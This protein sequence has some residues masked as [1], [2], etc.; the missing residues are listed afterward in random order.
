[1]FSLTFMYCFMFFYV[2]IQSKKIIHASTS[3]HDT[4]HDHQGWTATIETGDPR[5]TTL[6]QNF[7]MKSV[8]VTTEDGNL[9]STRT[10]R[11]AQ[12]RPDKRMNRVSLRL[13]CYPFVYIIC[14]LPLEISRLS[15]FAG[16]NWSLTFVYVGV[17]LF[18]SSGFLNALLYTTTRKGI[19]SWPRF[20]DSPRRNTAPVY[21][22]RERRPKFASEVVHTPPTATSTFVE[23]LPEGH[24]K[25]EYDSVWSR[26]EPGQDDITPD[27]SPVVGGH[28]GF[29]LV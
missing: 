4:L 12:L 25:E 15:Q 6:T 19:I 11:P 16:K 3:D 22:S 2:R 5:G 1:M 18:M 17:C 23:C 8:V 24:G 27:R 29:R 9:P 14:T 10:R 28:Q 21:V 26:E 7:T 13:L 20:L